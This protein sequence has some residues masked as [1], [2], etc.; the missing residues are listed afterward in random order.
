MNIELT[1]QIESRIRELAGTLCL[2]V[3]Q[4]LQMVLER[5]LS[6]THVGDDPM[7]LLGAFSASED[8]KVID[9]ALEIAMGERV[10][11]NGV[12]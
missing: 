11:R 4:V 12:T 3:E 9:D 6:F 5:G 2:P 10:K 8:R 1:P 7:V